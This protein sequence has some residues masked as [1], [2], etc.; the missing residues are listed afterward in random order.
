M[1]KD[2]HNRAAYLYLLLLFENIEELVKLL[3][4]EENDQC[5]SSPSHQDTAEDDDDR[6][7]V[8]YKMEVVSRCNENKYI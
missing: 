2:R 8:Y 7:W 1:E 6:P 4:E 5:P 3:K